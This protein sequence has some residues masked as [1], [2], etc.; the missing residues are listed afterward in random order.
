MLLLLVPVAPG[1]LGPKLTLA[2]GGI[3][4]LQLGGVSRTPLAAVRQFPLH[5]VLASASAV[6]RS[7]ELAA[8]ALAPPSVPGDKKLSQWADELSKMHA[9]VSEFKAHPMLVLLRLL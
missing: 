2:E 7:P 3:A 5:P 8:A 6:P 1:A 4:L 9:W